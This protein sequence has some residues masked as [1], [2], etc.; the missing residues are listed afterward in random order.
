MRGVINRMPKDNPVKLYTIE[1]ILKEEN[2]L[3]LKIKL[4]H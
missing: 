4:F 3:V 2:K 1:L